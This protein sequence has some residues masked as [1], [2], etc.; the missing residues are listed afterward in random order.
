MTSLWASKYHRTLPHPVHASC[1]LCVAVS[2]FR[3]SPLNVETCSLVLVSVLPRVEG[4]N[5]SL[6]R[7]WHMNYQYSPNTIFERY[8]QVIEQF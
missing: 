7:I 3:A 1:V 2:H 4:Y 6:A 8:I 5:S